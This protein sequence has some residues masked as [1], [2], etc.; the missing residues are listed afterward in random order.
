MTYIIV[1]DTLTSIQSGAFRFCDS[2]AAIYYYGTESG[3]D[4]VDIASQ[5]EPVE[6]AKLCIYAKTRPA[7]SGDFWYFDD[8]GNIKLWK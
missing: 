6:G 4:A 7:E 3:F 5:N 8:R 2:L 1:P